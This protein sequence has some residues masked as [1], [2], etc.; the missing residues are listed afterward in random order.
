MLCE[1]TFVKYSFYQFFLY[2]DYLIQKLSIKFSMIY[3]KSF[4]DADKTHSSIII[5][6]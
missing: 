4:F 5:I 1:Q 2:L 3:L 6:S